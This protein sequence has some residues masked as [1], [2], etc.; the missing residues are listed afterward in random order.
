M[1]RATLRRLAALG[2]AAAA[3]GALAPLAPWPVA[4]AAPILL[5][6][7]RLPAGWRTAGRWGALA[8]AIVAAAALAVALGGAWATATA[9]AA[10]GLIALQRLGARRA[11][12]DRA[13][14]PPTLL[15][16]ALAALVAPSA[17]T[18]LAIFAWAALA[19]IL[20]VLTTLAPGADERARVVGRHL[21]PIAA[22]TGAL[23][24]LLFFA[25]PRPRPAGGAL[26]ADPERA[27]VG[28]STRVDLAEI[29][30][31]LEDRAPVLRLAAA[32]D[33]PPP[34]LVSGLVL[35]QFDGRVWRSTAA[36]RPR[37]TVRPADALP[38][39]VQHGPDAGPVAFAPGPI[40]AI[41]SPDALFEPDTS[42]TWHL[43][44]PPRAVDYTAWIGRGPAAE[45]H[46]DDPRWTQ[47]PSLD[48]RVSPLAR[49]VVGEAADGV[50]AA[51]R[52]RSWLAANTTH[53]LVPGGSDGEDPVARFL[54]DRRAGHCGHHATA[55]AVIVRAAGHPA[56]L[57]HGYADLE[58][59]A[60][61]ALAR[62][63]HAHA[64]IEVLDEEGRW[65]PID[66][67]P[68]GPRAVPPPTVVGAALAGPAEPIAVALR[69]YDGSDQLTAARAAAFSA[70]RPWP[71]LA[72]SPVGRA[73]V[74]GAGALASIVV[75]AWALRRIARRLAGEAPRAAEGPVAGWHA[76]ARRAVARAGWQ[77]PP[78]LPPVEAADWLAARAPALGEALRELAWLHYRVRY[79]G[80]PDAAHAATARRLARAV[81]S[82]ARTHKALRGFGSAEP[83]R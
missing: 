33:A 46:P 72:A 1:T 61:Y 24:L 70:L 59:H 58:P 32:A 42:G 50:T 57:V 45:P 79:G 64:W 56:R 60:R 18:V 83:S 10:A 73:F 48:P 6:G 20:G 29:G 5:L 37:P 49:D 81:A 36:R 54:F 21:V 41:E 14:F 68:G 74:V 7:P 13:L 2:L 15:G 65:T 63:A 67:T 28:F 25:L 82:A 30:E 53:T 23:T 4:L 3:L 62:R 39:V 71:A 77:V 11:V 75:G 27:R 19:P 12:D 43:V 78:S 22:L 40:F 66:V 9:G 16:L 38:V 35:D 26:A 17:T 51:A 55:A 47:L 80:E 76:R 44:G 31:L 52:V 34:A 69:G 8:A